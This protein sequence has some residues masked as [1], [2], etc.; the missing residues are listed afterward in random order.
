MTA[1][2]RFTIYAP[3]ASWGDPAVGEIRGSWDRPSRS[4]LLGLV[5]AALG[6]LREDDP[7]H[8]RLDASLG[9]AVRVLAGGEGLVDYHTTQNPKA[10]VVKRAAPATR[11]DALAAGEPGTALSKRSLRQDALYVAALWLKPGASVT[12]EEISAALRSPVFTLYAG[13][14][15]N[16]LGLPLAP[17]IVDAESLA[18][19]LRDEPAL[20]EEFRYLRTRGAWGREVA[21]DPCDDFPPALIAEQIVTRRDDSPLRSRWQFSNRV[22]HIG[23]IPT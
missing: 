22:V 1:F 5:A 3:L 17:A 6:V 4:A 20:P 15:A 8:A 12:L 14:K 13:R 18:A 19:A 2:L 16:A 7:T 23:R 10:S 21:H 9:V 11:R